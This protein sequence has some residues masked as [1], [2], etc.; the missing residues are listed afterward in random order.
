MSRG[1]GKFC[2]VC[3]LPPSLPGFW[4]MTSD[5]QAWR[6]A[7]LALSQ[8]TS[9][10]LTHLFFSPIF[11]SLSVS[12]QRDRWHVQGHTF[13]ALLMFLT[14]V[15]LRKYLMVFPMK[16]KLACSLL[17][18]AKYHPVSL[19][20]LPDCNLRVDVS[21]SFLTEDIPGENPL[22]HPLV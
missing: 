1:R 4:G 19:D 21:D 22:V 12:H 20:S 16:E 13:L 2:E 7:Q 3:S 14:W 8:L 10:Q 5:G 18:Y 17:F 9:S 6:R 11:R 15:S